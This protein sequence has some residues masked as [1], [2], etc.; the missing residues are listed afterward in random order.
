MLSPFSRVRQCVGFAGILATLCWLGTPV[1]QAAGSKHRDPSI[2]ITFHAQ[3]NTLDPT[4]SVRVGVGSPPRQIIVEKIP[5]ISERDIAA[6]FPFKA[7]DGTFAAEFQLDRH[8]SVVLRR[9]ARSCAA[10][11]F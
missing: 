10:Q 2:A 8:G 3:A 6:F 9:D 5:S 7:A 1:G 4:F 11:S